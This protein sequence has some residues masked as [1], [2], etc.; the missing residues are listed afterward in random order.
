[1]NYFINGL[2]GRHISN[3]PVDLTD[4][5]NYSACYELVEAN[6]KRKAN[7]FIALKMVLEEENPADD[8]EIVVQYRYTG[9]PDRLEI[10]I[11]DSDENQVLND[12]A[13]LFVTPKALVTAN[14]EDLDSNETIE[15][16]VKIILDYGKYVVLGVQWAA[17]LMRENHE[18]TLDQYFD[19]LYSQEIH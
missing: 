19:E 12:G 5:S 10:L 3:F 15:D 7:A 8:R 18:G 1:M 4:F 9:K 16:I 13:P 14:P 6:L 2:S 17:F 11:I